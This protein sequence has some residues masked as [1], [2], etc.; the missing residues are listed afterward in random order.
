[1]PQIQHIQANE[2]LDSRGLPTL[3]CT[4]WID[5]GHSVTT[6]VPSGT[7]NNGDSKDE[8]YEKRDQNHRM[9]GQGVQSAVQLVNETIAPQLAG[10]DVFQQAAIDETLRQMD[11]T[12]TSSS[13]GVNSILVVSQAVWRAGA[14]MSGMEPY[15]YLNQSFGIAEPPRIPTTVFSLINGG[16]FGTGNLE[17][18]EFHLIPASYHSFSQALEIA[19]TVFHKLE[20]VLISKE[21]IHSVG[22]VGGYTPNLYNNTDAF[23][24]IIE[25]VKTT[26][27]TFAQDLFTGVDIAADQLKSGDAYILRD[28]GKKYTADAM[29]EYYQK[30]RSLYHSVYIEDPFAD[31]EEKDWKELMEELGETTTIVGDG[32][33]GMNQE[34]LQYAKDNKLCNA[35]AIKPSKIGTITESVQFAQKARELGMELVV[36]H[37]SGETNEDLIADLAVAIGA[38]FAKFG[39][40]NRGERI[41]KYNRLLAIERGIAQMEAA[42]QQSPQ[43]TQAQSQQ[44]T[45]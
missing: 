38:D 34:K 11:G 27:Y 16:S 6:S 41:A 37:R 3:E 30:L 28:E 4:L 7:K 5:S 26:Q 22:L 44:A 20:D 2:I 45:A 9:L 36:A 18:Q 23:E 31:S 19:V 43:A 13:F 24:L 29:H 8:A 42:A 40:P 14:L 25:S 12:E 15:A 10:K 1:M 17:I 39:P 35:V 21:A 32:L 33:V